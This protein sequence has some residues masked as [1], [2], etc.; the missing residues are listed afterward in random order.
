[1]FVNTVPYIILSCITFFMVP[2]KLAMALGS[3]LYY[4]LL[5]FNFFKIIKKL[6]TS[7]GIS[8]MVLI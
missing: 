1:M 5:K 2:S 3:V 6:V 7:L 8:M 4:S